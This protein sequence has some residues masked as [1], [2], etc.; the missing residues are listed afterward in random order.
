[1][2]KKSKKR[3]DVLQDRLRQR[4]LMLANARKQNDDPAETRRLEEEVA[5]LEAEISKL[6]AG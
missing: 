3:L 6:K 2:D 1:M 4:R 5:S